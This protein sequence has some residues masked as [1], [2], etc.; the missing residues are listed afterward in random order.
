MIVA[1][2]LQSCLN[3]MPDTSIV[4]NDS[5][6]LT[7]DSLI[8][9]DTVIYSTNGYTIKSNLHNSEGKNIEWTLTPSEDMHN[10]GVH[11][12]HMLV[13]AI[14]AMSQS[15]VSNHNNL[16]FDTN[17]DLY[18]AIGLT[19]AYISPEYSMQQ[20]RERV[21]NGVITGTES[22]FYPAFNNRMAWTNAAWKVY[23]VTGDKNWLK[24]AYKVSVATFEQE[25]DIAFYT[26]DW[27]VRGCSS[28]YTPIVEA[29][30][31]WM[32]NSDVFSTFTLSNNVETAAALH[33]MSEMGEELGEES[34]KYEKLS[35]DLTVSTNEELWNERH[36][37]YTA[38]VYGQSCD[39]H[40]PCCD[41]RAQALAVLWGM[42]DEDD[43]ASTLIE[44]TA[45]THCGVNNFYPS[46]NHS[47]EPC[48]SEASWGLTQGLWN[49][50]A[51]HVGNENA[52]RCGL[53]ALWRAQ[54][55]YSTLIINDGSTNMDVTCAISTLAMTHRLMA[56]MKFDAQGI[57]F[58]PFIP[59]CFTGDKKIL[60]FNYRGSSLDI[61][62]KG[63]GKDVDFI[64]LDDKR[65]DGNFISADKLKGHHSIIITMKQENSLSHQGVTVVTRNI[66][67][68]DEPEV[69]W[70]GDSARVINY[71]PSLKYKLL[72]DG[73]NYYTIN[74][75]VFAMP[76]IEN[77]AEVCVIASNRHCFSYTSRPF[78][79]GGRKFQRYPIPATS[80]NNDSINV[81]I[82]VP[83]GGNYMLSVNYTSP[84]TFSEVYV[85]SANTHRQGVIIL[86]GIGTDSISDQSNLIHVDLLRNTNTITLKRN[87]HNG[88]YNKKAARPL[89]LNIFK[90]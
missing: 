29:L 77:F 57:V 62:I 54:A 21:N 56:G 68:P 53:A 72:V 6:T 49:M 75:S 47:T 10:T 8:M 34:T 71:N 70:N 80:A 63:T 23:Q 38:M 13:N 26:R 25:Q 86:G 1:L 18:D 90:K 2:G 30:P 40:A 12:E 17:S 67:L 41:N 50:A 3:S 14:S 79:L 88:N 76:S 5:F 24:Y 19:L 87:S 20:L 84:I 83:E 11:T 64:L 81:T 7:G 35:H 28:D 58:E 51:A 82:S 74:D 4:T 33:V 89:T 39:L 16:H 46:R 9:G 48:L 27:L 37:Q 78:I 69:M 59:S 55:L 15:I 44:K 73:N 31:L 22:E 32:K 61:T 36:G 45:V 66:T 65:I 85:V 60:N 42:A 52:V 43:R